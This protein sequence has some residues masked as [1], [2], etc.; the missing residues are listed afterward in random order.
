MAVEDMKDVQSELIT[1][2]LESARALV[3]SG[4]ELTPGE[5]GIILYARS[6]GILTPFTMDREMLKKN[7]ANIT[8]VTENG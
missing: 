5:H 7:I 3:M 4:V 8:P 6:A 1:S 2:R